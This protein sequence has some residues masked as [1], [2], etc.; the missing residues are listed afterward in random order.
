MEISLAF[1]ILHNLSWHQL[2]IFDFHSNLK[3]PDPAGFCVVRDMGLSAAGS[4]DIAIRPL[5]SHAQMP[6]LT[7]LGA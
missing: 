3:S 2:P 1:Y 5:P 4:A 6:L 7:E